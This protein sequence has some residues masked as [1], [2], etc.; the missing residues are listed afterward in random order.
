VSRARVCVMVAPTARLR[1][2]LASTLRF[3]ALGVGLLSTGS[4]LLPL[5]KSV[6]SLKRILKSSRGVSVRGGTVIMV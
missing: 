2:P 6:S 5:P 4:C 1:W 3:F